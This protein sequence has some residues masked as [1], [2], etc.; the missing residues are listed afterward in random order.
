MKLQKFPDGSRRYSSKTMAAD[1]PNVLVHVLDALS[2]VR[3]HIGL[4]ERAARAA[5]T[6]N[7][8]KIPTLDT[9]RTNSSSEVSNVW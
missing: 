1:P 2:I 7:I 5:R 9:A 3:P 4:A 8:N 6:D